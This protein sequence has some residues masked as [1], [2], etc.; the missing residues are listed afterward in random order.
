MNLGNRR[1]ADLAA[2]IANVRVYPLSWHAKFT[3]RDQ[4]EPRMRRPNFSA[5]ADH[6]SLP[7]IVPRNGKAA[8]PASPERVR[9]LRKHLVLALRASRMMNNLEHSVSPVRPEPEGFAGRV[10]RT[11]CSLCKGWCCKNG[12][13]DAFL[14]EGTMACARRARS[15]WMRG[16]CCGYISNVCRRSG[17]RVRAYLTGGCGPMCATATSVVGS[18]AT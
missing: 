9:R 17:T 18:R 4:M 15:R 13:D 16:R 1:Q 8:I 2:G 6:D 14:D 3:L 12:A 11:A 7:V 10:A 5:D